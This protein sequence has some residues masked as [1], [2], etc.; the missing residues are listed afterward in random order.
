[1]ARKQVRTRIVSPLHSI[2]VHLPAV[3]GHVRALTERLDA[4]SVSIKRADENV[5]ERVL[6]MPPELL[7]QNAYQTAE[8]LQNQAIRMHAKGQSQEHLVTLESFLSKVA[9]T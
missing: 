5:L 2:D 6:A 3:A 1:M 7:P 8:R 4:S 9:A